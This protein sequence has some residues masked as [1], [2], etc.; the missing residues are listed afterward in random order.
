MNNGNSSSSSFSNK[1]QANTATNRKFT[2][3]SVFYNSDHKNNFY[4]TNI[5]ANKKHDNKIQHDQEKKSSRSTSSDHHVV[6][7][8]ITKTSQLQQPR[9]RMVS[10]IASSS[11]DVPSSTTTESNAG[12]NM[13]HSI[14]GSGKHAASALNV[15]TRGSKKSRSGSLNIRCLVLPS[16]VII[17]Y[18]LGVLSISTTKMVLTN[19]ESVGMTPRILTL[20]QLFIGMV[21]LRL[22][23]WMIPSDNKST[24]PPIHLNLKKMISISYGSRK[25]YDASGYFELLS[26]GIFFTLGFLFTNL[27]F[28]AADASFVETIKASE[29]ISSAGLSVLW[30]LETLSAKESYSLLGICVGVVISTVG[31]TKGANIDGVGGIQQSLLQSFRSSAIV[32]GS[33]I[34]FSFRGLYQKLFRASPMGRPSVV[35]DVCMQYLIHH[36]GVMVM[37]VFV[38]VLDAFPLV[39][40]WYEMMLS[41]DGVLSSNQIM[42]FV[43]LSLVNGLAFTHYK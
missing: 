6:S 27:S 35:N 2:S 34:C 15:S 9:K 19:Y 21:I 29:P 16:A 10:S 1:E 22:W 42:P 40:R 31:N 12:I 43:A 4:N 24:Y 26:S 25:E 28:S 18:I 11:G 7:N 8:G 14:K 5:A 30:K 20:Q 23:M 17:W 32:M 38:V 37:A 36:I 33:N 3:Y 39:M 41:T 13:D